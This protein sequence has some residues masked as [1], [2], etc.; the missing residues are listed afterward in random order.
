[1]NDNE[2]IT[3][4]DE[5]IFDFLSNPIVVSLVLGCT[6]Y[7]HSDI[8]KLYS[9]YEYE[10]FVAYQD[11]IDFIEGR[12]NKLPVLDHERIIKVFGM[13]M[14]L[15]EN[16]VEESIL[17]YTLKS[18]STLIKKGY[19]KAINYARSKTVLDIQEFDEY[20][21]KS[22]R[23]IGNFDLSF[24]YVIL[25]F[26]YIFR[27]NIDKDIKLT[28][29]EEAES[30]KSTV[31][32]LSS[33]ISIV[34]IDYNQKKSFDFDEDFYWFSKKD[35]VTISE[36]I[37]SLIDKDLER[38]KEIKETDID[39]D[40]YEKYDK[41]ELTYAEISKLKND[42]LGNGVYGKYINILNGIL[43]I[44]GENIQLVFDKITITKKEIYGC[45]PSDNNEP[46]SKDKAALSI[47]IYCYYKAIY[48]EMNSLKDL[49][50]NSSKIEELKKRNKYIDEIHLK[51]EKIEVLSEELT[52][53]KRKLLEENKELKK[54]LK[55]LEI[56]N[57]RL[58]S[59]INNAIDNT[60][61][62][63]KLR[64][65]MFNQSTN[66]D[67]EENN[68]VD[69]DALN[70][71]KVVIVGG[72]TNWQ[73]KMKEVLPNY[74]Y[75]SIENKNFDIK[76]LNNKDMIILNTSALSHSLYY[77]VINYVRDNDIPMDYLKPSLNIMKCI[78]DIDAIMMKMKKDN[79]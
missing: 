59:E 70:S 61:E 40:M 29:Y 58:K 43:L 23:N 78:I 16:K 79:I 53:T 54:Q 7:I 30:L 76:L 22:N 28:M 56:E 60:K 77:K 10:Y 27:D 38:R 36:Y 8:D 6:K 26:L 57:K 33:L 1:M 42:I 44:Q 64:E 48:T 21:L 12:Y 14:L 18:I 4:T 37:S 32:F 24:N 51:N 74:T 9:K 19:K 20:F 73:N 3:T 52:K 71:Y 67:I 66:E 35:E 41:N 39:Y 72:G 62:L 15:E 45:I 13:F 63:S 17:D 46:T 5:E 69:I 68:T 50:F 47:L 65:Y 25:V 34:Q 31:R 75:I 55:Q 2:L 11:N 49:Y